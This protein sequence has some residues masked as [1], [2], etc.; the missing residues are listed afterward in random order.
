LGSEGS[1]TIIK[2]GEGVNEDLVGTKVSFLEGAWGTH[3]IKDASYP[4]LFK[5]DKSADLKKLANSIVNPF[6]VCA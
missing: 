4:F 1:G 6:T 2:V 3:S 5:F